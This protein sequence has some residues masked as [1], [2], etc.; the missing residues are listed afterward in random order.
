LYPLITV[1]KETD[2]IAKKPT[3]KLMVNIV[4]LAIAAVITNISV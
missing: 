4:F 3:A 1:N 2:Y